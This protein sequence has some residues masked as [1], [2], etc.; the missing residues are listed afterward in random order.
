MES[1]FYVDRRLI[2][3]KKKSRTVFLFIPTLIIVV[4][5]IFFLLPKSNRNSSA[6]IATV[7]SPSPT[8]STIPTEEVQAQ[9]AGKTGSL[10]DAVSLALNGSHGI[11]GISIKNLETGETYELNSHK[12]FETASLYKLWV[13]GEVFSEIEDGTLAQNKVLSQDVAVLNRKFGIASD[14]AELSEGRVTRTVDD[15]LFRM[16]TY[17]DNYSAL[18]LTEKIKLTNLASFLKENGLYES[19]VGTSGG[20]PTSTSADI[21]LFLEKLYKGELGDQAS[22]SQ[23]VKLLKGQ[24]LNGKLPRYLP[25]EIEIA[26]KTGE[27]G[28]V[29]HDAGIIYTPGG[30]Y[31]IVIMSD[32]NSRA[33]ADE[34]I[35]AISKNVY[36]Y[37]SEK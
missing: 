21:S 20:D 2:T 8:A 3:P 19:A 18:I 15:A 13:M 4:I 31:I 35:A 1:Y 32:S 34:R 24:T 17:S 22:T 36:D 16:I 12:K 6:Q 9:V 7:I 5:L 28:T 14:S 26:H 23:M 10:E 29:S 33:G 27:L 11:Y 25:E 30:D 37:F